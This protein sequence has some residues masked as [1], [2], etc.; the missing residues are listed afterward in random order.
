MYNLPYNRREEMDIK[1]ESEVLTVLK[2][3]LRIILKAAELGNIRKL[4]DD[5][6]TNRENNLLRD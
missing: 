2:R 4:R 5:F 1:T 3:A 6:A